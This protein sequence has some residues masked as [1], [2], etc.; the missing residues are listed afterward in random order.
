MH[1]DWELILSETRSQIVVK[2]GEKDLLLAARRQSDVSLR[3][4]ETAR[5]LQPLMPS[6]EEASEY[7]A[8]DP[9][10]CFGC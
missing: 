10:N 5:R 8:Q 2:E 6:L 4:V 7:V 3:Q 1:L 9:V